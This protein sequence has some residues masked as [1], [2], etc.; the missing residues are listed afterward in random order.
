MGLG[1]TGV[2]TFLALTAF[3]LWYYRDSQAGSFRWH[4]RNARLKQLAALASLF[5]LAMAASYAVLQ[6]AWGFI[7]L[8]VA[9]KTGTWW[10]RLLLSQRA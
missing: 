5:F 6:Q 1:I 9:V 4:W 8:I 10:L 3:V 7:Y 2:L